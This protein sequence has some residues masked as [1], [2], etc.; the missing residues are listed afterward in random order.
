MNICSC[1]RTDGSTYLRQFG[2]RISSFSITCQVFLSYHGGAKG[3]CRATS[4]T[5]GHSAAEKPRPHSSRTRFT[6]AKISHLYFTVERPCSVGR[7]PFHPLLPGVEAGYLVN[8]TGSISVSTPGA[9]K[10]LEI[11]GRPQCQ[12]GSL[13]FIRESSRASSWH[14]ELPCSPSTSCALYAMMLTTG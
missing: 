11:T 8:D 3:A 12:V 4:C 13:M 1:P 2:Y 7:I 14:P 10:S 9:S 6:S 5:G